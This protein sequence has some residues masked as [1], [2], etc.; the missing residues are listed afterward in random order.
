MTSI[1]WVRCSDFLCLRAALS[2]SPSSRPRLSLSKITNQQFIINLWFFGTKCFKSSVIRRH[3]M[4]KVVWP[5]LSSPATSSHCLHVYKRAVSFSYS[6]WLLISLVFYGNLKAHKT[7]FHET[8]PSVR[9]QKKEKNGN[10]GWGLKLIVSAQHALK[11]AIDQ[12]KTHW[13][14]EK[15]KYW[16]DQAAVPKFQTAK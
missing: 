1:R 11:E 14:K 4:E 3:V 13:K 2:R 10:L 15:K 8:R 7:W 16:Q 9:E 6:S 5:S 12:S